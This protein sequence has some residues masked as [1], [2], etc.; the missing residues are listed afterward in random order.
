MAPQGLEVGLEGVRLAAFGHPRILREV[1][2]LAGTVEHAGELPAGL[3]G[4]HARLALEGRIDV[5]DAVVGRAAI[6]VDHLVQGD[7][8]RHAGKQRAETLLALAQGFVCRGRLER[9]RP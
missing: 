6:V 5:E 4:E 8:L 7:S 2:R 9:L 1:R 3:V